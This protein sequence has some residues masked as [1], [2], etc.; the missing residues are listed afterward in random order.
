MPTKP[1]VLSTLFLMAGCARLLHAPQAAPAPEVWMTYF[2]PE[3]LL[4]PEAC[5]EGTRQHLDVLEFYINS[6]IWRSPEEWRPLVES[7][8]AN[9]VEIAVEGGLFDW[10]N[11]LTKQWC[12]PPEPI[13]LDI[14]RED[15]HDRV[16]EETARMELAKIESL[17]RAG[18]VPRYLNMDGTVRRML[19]PGQDLGR[20]DVRGFDSL[21]QCLQE[22]VDYMRLWREAFPQI[23]FFSCCNFPNWGWSG[24]TSY[25]DGGMFNGDYAEVFPRVMAAAA[26]AGVPFDGVTVDY[27]YEYATGEQPHKPWLDYADQAQPTVERDPHAVDWWARLFDL[28]GVVRG[29]GLEFNII[30]NSQAGGLTSGEAFGEK[31]LEYLDEYLNRG[32][33][34]E[35]IIIQSW[36]PHPEKASPETEPGTMTH[37]TREVLRRVHQRH[38]PRIRP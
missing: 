38:Q 3:E 34:A 26:E 20:T 28:E 2:R 24:S 14:V 7:L 23:R 27:P 37:V 21:D 4:L 35:R 1:L 32:G 22:M 33:Q 9:G 8:Q 5:W 10:D 29:R 31:T 11:K 16:G 18:G 19:L 15:W 6:I 13:T 12:L 17:V 30:L 25:W 36:Y